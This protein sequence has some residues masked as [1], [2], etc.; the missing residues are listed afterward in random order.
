MEVTFKCRLL[1]LSLLALVNFAY[2]YHDCCITFLPQNLWIAHSL[3]FELS[4]Q[5]IPRVQH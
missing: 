5:L 4:C 2:I 1:G 3:L